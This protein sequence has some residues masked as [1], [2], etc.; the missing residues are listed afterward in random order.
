MAI[1]GQAEHERESGQ[2]NRTARLPSNPAF[3]L[4]YPLAALFI[5]RTA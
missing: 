3:E 5:G 2:H 4:D 1:S